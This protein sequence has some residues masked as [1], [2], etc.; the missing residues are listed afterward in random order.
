M[1]Q[2]IQLHFKEIGRIEPEENSPAQ[3]NDELESLE[4]YFKTKIDSIL[5]D[6][7]KSYNG[8]IF[9]EIVGIGVEKDI[10]ILE[11][12]KFIDFGRFFSLGD[13]GDGV[14]DIIKSNDGIFG[15]EFLPFAEALEGDFFA[16]NINNKT[17]YF[18]LHDFN[19]QEEPT[20]K[21]AENAEQFFLS[22]TKEED[23]ASRSNEKQ[24]IPKLVSE[25][26]SNSLLDKLKKFKDKNP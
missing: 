26:T 7:W 14:I 13:N 20:H 5:K 19:D 25:N 2:A 6:T 18:I 8:K 9:S 1:N 10:P 11:G 3:I 4:E 22:L 24:T 21:I 16:Y 23:E 12:S 17:I 15:K